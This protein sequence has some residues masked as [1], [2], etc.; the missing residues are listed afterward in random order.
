MIRK[1]KQSDLSDVTKI[2]DEIIEWEAAGKAVIGWKKGVYPTEQTASVAHEKGELFV[3]EI[4]GEVVAAAII[5]QEQVAEY[6]DCTWEFPVPDNEIMVI[7]TLVVAPA[8]A[9]KGYATAFI[10]FYEGYALDNGCHYLR[11]DTNEKNTA[12][13]K[14]YQKLGYRE[15]GIVTCDF[16][17]IRSIQLVCL[18]KKLACRV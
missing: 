3:M 15:V 9:G 14:L 10:D 1:S 2:Y 17:D 6:A 13:R 18:E 8:Q 5:N 11:L 7:H 16:N 4:A 12:A